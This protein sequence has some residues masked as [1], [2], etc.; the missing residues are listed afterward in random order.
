MTR[1]Y[2]NYITP[3]VLNNHHYSLNQVSKNVTYY[4]QVVP[5][6][7]VGVYNL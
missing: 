5:Y 3:I 6:C 7:Y 4:S 2:D 1:N